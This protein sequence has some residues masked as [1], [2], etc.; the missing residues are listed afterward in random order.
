MIK[1][2]TLTVWKW[3]YRTSMS[4]ETSQRKVLLVG[5]LGYGEF[6]INT[7]LPIMTSEEHHKSTT[8]GF[9]TMQRSD[10]FWSGVCWDIFC[11]TVKEYGGNVNDD[12][13]LPLQNL[14]HG[15]DIDGGEATNC[16]QIFLR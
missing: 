8:S 10:R 14:L 16:Q 15:T 13:N 3:Q 2:R 11:N 5:G 9:F 4:L 12:K 1:M 7:N 6:T